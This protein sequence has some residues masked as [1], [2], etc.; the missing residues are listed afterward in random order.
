MPSQRSERGAQGRG[1][2]DAKWA[3]KREQCG[4]SALRR[5][6]HSLHQ[7]PE[8]AIRREARTSANNPPAVTPDQ[9]AFRWQLLCSGDLITV[10]YAIFRP[11]WSR[12]TLSRIA[13]VSRFSQSVRTIAAPSSLNP[14]T[15]ARIA[16][17]I[18]LADSTSCTTSCSVRWAPEGGPA[19]GCSEAN[20]G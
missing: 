5:V 12:S 18:H 6:E 1:S 3:G 15:S 19:G 10:V 2:T 13:M 20:V 14:G 17:L 9:Q 16:P 7:I 11:T 8:K 4:G